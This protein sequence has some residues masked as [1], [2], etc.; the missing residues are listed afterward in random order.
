MTTRYLASLLLFALLASPTFAPA[1]ELPANEQLAQV[2]A[3][4]QIGAAAQAKPSQEELEKKF[5]EML[6]GATLKG[7]FTVTGKDGAPKAEKYTLGKVA[8]TANGDYWL[9]QARIQYG[10]NDVTLPL[11]L[12]VKWAGDTPVII[13][14]KLPVPPLGVYTARVMFYGNQYAGTWD[15]GDHGGQLFGEVVPAEKD[16]EKPADE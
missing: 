12:Q 14:D 11:T 9:F 5:G 10:E 4:V 13:V 8:K 2:G 1:E 15:G 6:S 16:G 7:S 3:T